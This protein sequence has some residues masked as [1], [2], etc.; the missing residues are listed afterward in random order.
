MTRWAQTFLAALLAG[1]CSAAHAAVDC[2][3]QRKSFPKNW[4]AVDKETP[5]LRCRNRYVDLK[6]FLSQRDENTSML[7][8]VNDSKVYRAIIDVSAVDAVKQQ[9]GLYILHSENTCF[10]RGVYSQPAVL[11]FGDKTPSGVPN[12]LFAMNRLDH[13]VSCTPV[14]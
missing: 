10:I 14:K 8:V 11:H 7:T 2:D 3:I 5:A 4:A 9:S 6:I 12:F 1:T 13:F